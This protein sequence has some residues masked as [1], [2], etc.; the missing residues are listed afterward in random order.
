[1]SALSIRP[2]ASDA[3]EPTGRFWWTHSRRSWLNNT[4]LD[5][6]D[7]SM[8]MTAMMNSVDSCSA[9]TGSRSRD[10]VVTMTTTSK[11]SYS[12]PVSWLGLPQS[13]LEDRVLSLV[14]N[15]TTTTFC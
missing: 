9:S 7:E 5:E 4:G 12:V 3:F 15:N 13:V 2:T 8:M 10:H 14:P 11:Q 1:M 6:D